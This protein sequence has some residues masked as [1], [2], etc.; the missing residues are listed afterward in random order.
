MDSK[1]RE[2]HAKISGMIGSHEVVCKADDATRYAMN[3]LAENFNCV[4]PL[5]DSDTKDKMIT[6]LK[7]L[8]DI[9]T[10]VHNKKYEISDEL[11]KE[12]GQ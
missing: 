9:K 10:T 6:V 7:L 1:T 2:R 3:M 8:N 12:M 5:I 11:K 4:R